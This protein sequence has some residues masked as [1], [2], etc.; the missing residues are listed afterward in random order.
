[1]RGRAVFGA[2]GAVRAHFHGVSNSTKPSAKE[3]VSPNPPSAHEMLFDLNDDRK[4]VAF[5]VSCD[6]E[7]NRETPPESHFGKLIKEIKFPETR[8]D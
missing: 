8:R 4:N 3:A 7:H 2:A 6:T 1:L 5:A